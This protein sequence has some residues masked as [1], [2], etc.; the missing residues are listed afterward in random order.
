MC[1]DFPL[2]F[3][4]QVQLRRQLCPRATALLH[5]QY[6]RRSIM[7]AEGG[8]LPQRPPRS[9]KRPASA[10]SEYAAADRPAESA[11]DSAA[12]LA[13]EQPDAPV[14]DRQPNGAA[15][16][17]AAPAAPAVPAMPMQPVS[18]KHT[19]GALRSAR[20][21]SY[22][23]E[24]EVLHSPFEDECAQWTLCSMDAENDHLHSSADLDHTADIQL[25]A[26][27]SWL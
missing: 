16:E 15:A 27:E 23:F 11:C 9:R 17:A 22:N 21:E 12:E 10:V 6:R 14:A 8:G 2:G 3:R 24:C 5:S 1:Q 26:C 18:D 25:H 13:R 20:V 7:E 19:P 4:M